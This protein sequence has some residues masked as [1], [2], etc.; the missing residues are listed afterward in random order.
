VTRASGAPGPA[1]REI[2]GQVRAWRAAVL[3]V[4]V[5]LTSS[6]APA[7][8]QEPA[9]LLRIEWGIGQG[10]G[11]RPAVTGYLVNERGY[12]AIEI[13]L[14]LDRLD[15]AGRV[16]RSTLV[17]IDAAVPPLGRTYFEIPIPEA[18]VP[19]ATGAVVPGALAREAT[20]ASRYDVRLA[21]VHWACSGGG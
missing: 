13:Q 11:G 16:A 19:S 18:A 21:Q 12:R 7:G 6:P 4:A 5:L 1:H 9:G 3:A 17:Y 15:A 2:G 8:S 20:G 14:T 10:R